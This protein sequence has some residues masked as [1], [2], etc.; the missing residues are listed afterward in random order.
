MNLN[1]VKDN[2]TV[3]KMAKNACEIAKYLVKLISDQSFLMEKQV[4]CTKNTQHRLIQ[5]FLWFSKVP[6][7][8]VEGI[9]P[10]LDIRTLLNCAR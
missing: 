4:S 9:N 7:G 6:G 2:H 3:G 8:S 5:Y 10:I 1:F